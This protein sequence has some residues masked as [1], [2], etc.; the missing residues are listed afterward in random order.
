[1]KKIK[2]I[3]VWS[4]VSVA[5][6]TGIQ[7]CDLEEYNPSGSTADVVFSTPEGIEYLVN[8]MY[9]NFRWKYFGREDPVLYL[10]GGT[11]LWYNAGREAYGNGMTQYTD[12]MSPTLGQ[13]AN[14][15]NRVYDDINMCNSVI[16]RIGDVIYQNQKEKAYREGEAR[17]LRSYCY[18]WLCEF[19]GDVELRLEETSTPSFVAY[20]TPAETI[21]DEV[22]IP[23]AQK[24]CEQLQ[25]DPIDGMIGRYTRKA[26]YGLLARVALTRASYCTEGS[27]EQKTFLQMAK[28]AADYVIAHKSELGIKLYDTYNEVWKAC[29]N[30]SNSEYLAVVTHSS[31]STNNPQ[32]KNPNRLYLYFAPKLLNCLG[33]KSGWE[34]PKEGARMMPTRYLLQLFEE[35][36]ARYDVIFQE[37]FLGTEDF[38]WTESS[39]DLAKYGK[40]YDKIRTRHIA[41][42]DTCLYFTR[43]S[44]PQIQK[45]TARY[46]VVD[47]NTLY[48]A[49]G[50]IKAV[51]EDGTTSQI[52]YSFPRFQKYRIYDPD[53][54]TKLLAAPNG[55]VGFADV[56]LMRYAEMPLIAAECAIRMG[57]AAQA[58]PYIT[59][60][61]SRIV[62][63]GYEVQMAVK[64]GDMTI[65][66]ILDERARELCGEWLRW[67]DLKR[68]GKLVEYIKAHNP[69]VAPNIKDYHS[70][71]PIP[72]TFL[73]KLENAEEFGQNPGY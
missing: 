13:L 26:A 69:D 32:S 16:N 30:K 2:N 54:D 46:V 27:E 31:I 7:S 56:P 23:D 5:T 37:A 40:A 38:T 19:F 18:W 43:R 34:Y 24:A 49:D 28:D 44:I 11:D 42:G 65:D 60:L 48:N 22:I 63:P 70:L 66:F 35:G 45:D 72:S 58:V 33:C 67:M 47:V 73:D 51:G 4:L 1:M 17:W 8:R 3:I 36:D 39:G 71:R 6:M 12:K 41:K 61:R 29:N 62:K 9:Y 21:Y 59:D 68:T 50:T 10:E 55:T 52:T 64:T 20:R 53:S 25:V 14:V 15:W 57:N